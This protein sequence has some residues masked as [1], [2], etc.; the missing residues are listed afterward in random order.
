MVQATERK[1]HGI[2]AV[3]WWTRERISYPSKNEKPL[4]PHPDPSVTFVKTHLALCFSGV[5]T[6]SAT[7]M[8]IDARTSG[9][10]AEVTRRRDYNLLLI[11]ANQ[12]TI[13][14]R[15]RVV[16]EQMTPMIHRSKM[17]RRTV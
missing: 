13:L 1:L 17:V 14:W 4:L 6:S 2:S 5:K 3:P 9:L 10:L 16:R 12:R 8:P 15:L 11:G 7:H